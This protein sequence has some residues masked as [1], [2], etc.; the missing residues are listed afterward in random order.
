MGGV[1][2]MAEEKAAK[3]PPIPAGKNL[4][5]QEMAYF[6]RI[7]SLCRHNKYRE[8]ESLL[9]K[10]A[11]VDATDEFGNTPLVIAA[12]NGYKRMTKLLLRH[13]A[14]INAQNNRGNTPL[15]FSYAY[16][17]KVLAEYLKEKGAD[18]TIRNDGGLRVTRAWGSNNNSR[19]WGS[20]KG[21]CA[22]T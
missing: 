5:M 16:G 18:D 1:K 9:E 8:I 10:G 6:N 2:D 11:P 3:E 12:Q 19:A 14:D 4:T 13:N 21:P 20:G 7:Y 17:F 22:R 15:H